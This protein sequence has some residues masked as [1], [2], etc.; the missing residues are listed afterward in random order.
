[1]SEYYLPICG[2]SFQVFCFLRDSGL[3]SY[4][5]PVSVTSVHDPPVPFHPTQLEQP[6][7]IWRGLCVAK[8]LTVQFSPA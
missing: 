4:A 8:C 1:M 3:V 7:F 6:D 5:F 2:Y